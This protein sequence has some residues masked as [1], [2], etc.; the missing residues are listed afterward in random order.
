VTSWQATTALQFRHVVSSVRRAAKGAGGTR[1]EKVVVWAHTPHVGN[2]SAA[3]MGW[4]GQFDIGEL[5]RTASGRRR[6]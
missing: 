5:R 3:A 1:Q 6:R 2:A 4:H